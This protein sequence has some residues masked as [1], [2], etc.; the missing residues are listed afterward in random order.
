MNKSKR[1]PATEKLQDIAHQGFY[2]VIRYTFA[3][4]TGTFATFERAL[5]TAVE[6]GEPGFQIVRITLR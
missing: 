5:A 3:G 6:L 4:D 2:F 1:M